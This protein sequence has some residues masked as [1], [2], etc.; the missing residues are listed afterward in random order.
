[1]TM[2]NLMKKS[3]DINLLST[4]PFCPSGGLKI[5]ILLF[6]LLGSSAYAQLEEGPLPASTTPGTARAKSSARIQSHEPLSLPFW[7]DFSGVNT[8]IN[9]APDTNF[10]IHSNSVFITEGDGIFPPS[11]NVGV[12]N[13]QDSLGSPYNPNEPTTNGFNDKLISQKIKMSEVPANERNTVYLSFFFQWKGNG[14]T[15]DANDFLRVEF[16]NDQN[17]WVTIETIY[18]NGDFYDSVFYIKFIPV[19]GDQYFHDGFQFRLRSY[20]RAS[21]PFDS[22]IVDYFYLNKGRDG[23]NTLFPDRA[24]ASKI[25]PLMGTYNSVP[26]KHFLVNKSLDS[27]RFDV[28]N[29]RTPYVIPASISY[30]ASAEFINYPPDPLNNPPVISAVPLVISNPVGD[31]VMLP[32]ERNTAKLDNLPDVDDPSQFDPMA[33]SVDV[34]LKMRVISGDD[35]DPAKGP[36][37]PIDFSKNDTVT[38]FYN[39]RSYYAYDDGVAE[40]TA[41]LTQPGNRLAYRFEMVIDTATIYGV[42]VY[43]A[44]TGGSNTQTVDFYLYGDDNGKPSSIP[45]QSFLGR[46]ISK[47]GEN[48]F[49]YIRFGEP[50]FLSK[51]VFYFGWKEP[52]SGSVKVGLDKNNDTNENIFVYVN[53]EWSGNTNV[54]GSLMIRPSFGKGNGV[55]TALP[56]EE[57]SFTLYPNPGSGIFFLPKHTQQVDVMDVTSKRTSVDM[58]DESDRKKIS[59]QNPSSGIY[60]VRWSDRFGIHSSKLIVK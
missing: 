49:I 5:F 24:A 37:D 29:L 42:Y 38:A 48:R 20:G 30:S 17:T 46:T 41:G 11:I 36:F 57:K 50:I 28:I 10:W 22:W 23:T 6:L 58:E 52:T 43:F 51:P 25:S 21:G 39:L 56:G 16:L 54:H 19:T 7:D 55:I 35:T 3:N 2:K 27:V 40:Y 31:G 47:N 33:D 8:K 15:P 14:E 18:G 34:K 12:F 9:H 45:I 44:Y 59:I 60:I 53:G 4:F 13:G 1:M 26:Y 32:G